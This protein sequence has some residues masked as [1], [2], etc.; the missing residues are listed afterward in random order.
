[1]IYNRPSDP[2]PAEIRRRCLE[3]QQ[4]WTEEER[5]RRRVVKPQPVIASI[6]RERDLP[7]AVTLESLAS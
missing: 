1:M 6:V 3:I 2:S 4:Q 7:L 5:E